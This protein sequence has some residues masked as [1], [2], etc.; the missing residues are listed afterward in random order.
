M[1]KRS[2]SWSADPV[3]MTYNVF[4]QGVDGCDPFI[5]ENIASHLATQIEK[6]CKRYRIDPQPFVTA[7]TGAN[8][9]PIL[10][11][12]FLIGL[13]YKGMNAK[14]N[15]DYMIVLKGLRKFIRTLSRRAH[16]CKE[17]NDNNAYVSG[18]FYLC[19][20]MGLIHLMGEDYINQGIVDIWQNFLSSVTYT[21]VDG[22]TYSVYLMCLPDPRDSQ[23]ICKYHWISIRC[24]KRQKLLKPALRKIFNRGYVFQNA[25]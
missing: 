17:D 6:Y 10:F 9:G 3:G 4:R 12:F 1:R 15:Y 2:K 25:D 23:Y 11:M 20:D 22:Y 14:V 21:Q 24:D 18:M 19:I 8:A 7:L 5:V 13:E 16:A